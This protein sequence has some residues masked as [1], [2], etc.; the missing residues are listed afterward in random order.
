MS[1][2]NDY[3]FNKTDQQVHITTSIKAIGDLTGL[4]FARVL[5]PD[6]MAA[7]GDSSETNNYRGNGTV[8]ANDLVYAEA[9]ASKYV[10][11]LY[12][13]TAYQHNSA[14]TDWTTDTASYLNGTNVG[15]GDNTIGLG[16]LLGDLLAGSSLSFNYAYIFGT[17]I[18]SAIGSANI[19]GTSKPAS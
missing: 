16:F 10:I 1:I 9:L 7:P 18:S 15:H 12:T 19:T 6:A 5:D 14:V 3:Y 4:S 11:G 13:T 8:S 2:T 17:D